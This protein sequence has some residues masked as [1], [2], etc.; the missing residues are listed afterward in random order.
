MIALGRSVERDPEGRLVISG[1]RLRAC[2]RLELLATGWSIEEL[3][4]SYPHVGHDGVRALFAAATARFR[5]AERR[6]ARRDRRAGGND[7]A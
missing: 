2:F 5:T 3:L 4:A 7:V 1:T 6:T